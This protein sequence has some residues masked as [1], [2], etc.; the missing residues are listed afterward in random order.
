MKE[1]D[2]KGSSTELDRFRVFFEQA[3]ICVHEID[4]DGRLLTMNAAGL[5]LAGVHSEEEIR[6]RSYLDFVSRKDEDRIR[7]LLQRAVEG[8]AS[9]FEFSSNGT[10]HQRHFTSCFIPCPDANGEICQLLGITTDITEHKEAAT[11]LTRLNRTYSVLSGCN[12]S[13]AGAVDEQHLL[14]AF[15]N[16]LVDVGGYSFAWVGYAKCEPG[17][18]ISMKAHTGHRDAQ[19]SAQVSAWAN[20][21]DNPS[22]CRTAVLTGHP[23]V[24][25]DIEAEPGLSHWRD[26]AKRL[27]FRSVI[28]LPLQANGSA[29]GN[30]SIFSAE[31]NAFT[32]QEIRLLTDLAKDLA[33][34][35]KTARANATRAQRVRRL[36]EE[37]EHDERNRIAAILHDG[38]G[39]SMQAVNL[40]LKRLRAM[41]D[42]AQPLD[43][44]ILSRIIAEVR[45]VIQTLRKI[46]HELRPPFLG[47]MDLPEA[48][49]F[50]HASRNRQRD[51]IRSNEE[52]RQAGRPWPLHDPRAG[53]ERRRSR[54]DQQH[55]RE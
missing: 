53:G 45:E 46:S 36:R 35:I 15:C 16:I 28:A 10:A 40:G 22:P 8:N 26:T 47:R 48:V 1:R 29:V 18:R 43:T 51:R 30:F 12:S 6:G 34:G 37:A 25:R 17:L 4:T 21:V 41:A 52:V 11:G 23:A 55:A 5:D 19:L 31:K 3:P 50:P 54:R 7:R 13:L 27:G 24:F 44:D 20:T 9:Q 14:N 2:K 39:Q 49:R 42:D 32:E 33:F 38:V